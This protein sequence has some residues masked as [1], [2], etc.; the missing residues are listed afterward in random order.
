MFPCNVCVCPKYTHVPNPCLH[1]MSPMVPLFR[2]E[3]QSEERTG[4]DPAEDALAALELAQYFIN[5][6]PR[7]V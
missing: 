1:T 7:Q 6:G 2:K 5:K 3:I 4:H